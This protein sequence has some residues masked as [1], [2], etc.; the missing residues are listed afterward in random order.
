M[1]DDPL[2]RYAAL[3][4]R[5]HAPRDLSRAV[6]DRIDREQHEPARP[7]GPRHQARRNGPA[8]FAVKRHRFRGFALEV[9]CPCGVGDR[10][11]PAS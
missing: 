1:T 5:A 10:R 4:N 6:L 2:H 11:I 3:I 8:P 7:S 9:R